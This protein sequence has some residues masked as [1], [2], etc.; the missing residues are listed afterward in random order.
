MENGCM[1]KDIVLCLLLAFILYGSLEIVAAVKGQNTTESTDFL[2]SL[3][4]ALSVALWA[5]NDAKSRNLYR[6]YEYSHFI[7]LI[8]PLALPYHLIKTRGSEGLLIFLGLLSL[9]PLPFFSGLISWT[10]FT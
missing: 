9:Y 3:F 10:Y 1:Q 2:C 4:F 6:P 8:W 7:F 5:S